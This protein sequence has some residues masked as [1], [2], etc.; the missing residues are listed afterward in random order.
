MTEQRLIGAPVGSDRAAEQ[1]S[2]QD[3]TEDRSPGHGVKQ[4]AD[5]LDEAER[6]K[7]ARIP[8]ELRQRIARNFHPEKLGRDRRNQKE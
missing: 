7:M 6:Q 3:R 2:G 4:S 1:R 8:S 5:E